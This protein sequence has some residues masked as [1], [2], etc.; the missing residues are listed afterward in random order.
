[1]VQLVLVVLAAVAGYAGYHETAMFARE[2]PQ[3]PLGVAPVLWGG[4]FGTLA[5]VAAFFASPVLIAA[6][7]AWAGYRE[8]ATLEQRWS[9][10]L[11]GIS[12]RFWAVS[13]GAFGLGGALIIPTEMWALFCGGAAVGGAFFVLV[14]ERNAL[15]DTNRALASERGR[16]SRDATRGVPGRDAKPQTSTPPTHVLLFER[17]SATPAPRPTTPRP[18]TPPP[19]VES[20][21]ILPRRR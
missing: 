7:V 16:L 14:D 18:T 11:F 13:C 2:G 1:M 21:N 12:A 5:L 20:E 4:G 8:I 3:A 10:P 9:A 19:R 6:F 15:I 17:A